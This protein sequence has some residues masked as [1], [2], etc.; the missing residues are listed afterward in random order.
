M[1]CFD[2]LVACNCVLMCPQL[3][4]EVPEALFIWGSR[5]DDF[6]VP[7]RS[8]NDFWL[9]VSAGHDHRRAIR[10]S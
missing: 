2:E 8:E 4:G 10:C 3:T 7:I 6:N 5:A 1:A 9:P